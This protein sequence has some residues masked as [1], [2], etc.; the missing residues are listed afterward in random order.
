[1]PE[2]GKPDPPAGRWLQEMAMTLP[3]K[4]LMLGI[5]ACGGFYVLVCRQPQYVRAA[6]QVAKTA[7]AKT[8][9][10][11]TVAKTAVKKTTKMPA[12]PVRGFFRGIIRR[13]VPKP[14]KTPILPRGKNPIKFKVKDDPKARARLIRARDY[15]DSR[16]PQDPDD[17]KRLRRAESLVKDGQFDAAITLVQRLLDRQ[18][19]TLIRNDNEEWV[20][21]RQQANRLLSKF[22]GR[23]REGYR[24]KYGSAARDLLD[25]G[26][27]SGDLK[28]LADVATRYFHT[29]AG[30]EAARKLAAIYLDRGEYGIAARWFARVLEAEPSDGGDPKWLLQAAYAFR[31]AGDLPESKQL[32]KRV[33]KLVADNSLVLG[34]HPV[35]PAEWLN[36]FKAASGGNTQVSEWWTLFGTSS[37]TGTVD[38]GDPLL[39]SR[40]SQPTT[41]SHIVHRHIDR[42]LEALTDN[43]RAVIPAAVPLTVGGKVVF[44]TLRGILVV[45]AE[46]GS[47][48]WESREGISAE[49]LLSGRVPTASYD[50]FSRGYYPSNNNNGYGDYH[51]L[52][53]LLF[54]NGNY[55][56]ISSDGTRLFVIENMALLP[57]VG[58]YARYS[59]DPEQ[60]DRYR[61]S[62][63][64]NKLTAYDLN[65][66]RPVWEIGGRFRSES[67]DLQL[68][69]NYFLGVPVADRGEL[70]VVGEKDSRI[71]LHALDAKTG[72]VKWSRLIAYSDTKISQD[73]VR[74][75]I[76]AQVAVR[77]GVIVCPTS[78]GW[79]VAVD[80][81]NK[82]ILWAHRYSKPNA[83][84][85]EYGSSQVIQAATLNQRWIPSAPVISGGLVVY[86]PQEDESIVCLRLRDGKRLWQIPKGDYLYHAGVFGG[87]V[88]L[89]GKDR[90]TAVKLHDGT[91]AW[92]TPIDKSAGMPSGMGVAVG[93]EYHVPLYHGQLWTVN[94]KTGKVDRKLYLPSESQP[95]GNLTMYR[96]QVLSLTPF[97]LT[98]FEQRSALLAKIAQR[99]K[100]AR[101]DP[102]AALKEAEIAL[103]RRDYKTALASLRRVDAAKLDPSLDGRYRKAMMTTLTSVVRSDFKSHD[104]ELRQLAAFVK[105]PSEKFE[106]HR[107][108]AERH[109]ARNEFHDAFQLYRQLAR[110]NPDGPVRR[111]DDNRLETTVRFWAAGKLRDVWTRMPR[112]ARDSLGKQLAAEAAGLASA[113]SRKRLRF[114][115]LFSFHP[116]AVT[117]VK[118][119]IDESIQKGN[120]AVAEQLLTRLRRHK[121]RQIA[122]VAMERYARLLLTRKLPADAALVYLELKRKFPDVTL[123]DGRTAVKLVAELQ[124]RK[125]VNL[126][127]GDEP[128]SW[129]KSTMRIEQSGTQ[130]RSYPDQQLIVGTNGFPYFRDRSFQIDHNGQQLLVTR[131]SDDKLTW[132]VPLRGQSNASTGYYVHGASSGHLVFVLYRNVLHCLSPVDHRVVW[133]R[134]L[135]KRGTSGGMYYSYYSSSPAQ[136][137]YRPLT[138][139]REVAAVLG[140]SKEFSHQGGLAFANEN[141]VGIYGRRRLIV[142][143]TLSGN[144]LWMLRG[145]TQGSRAVATNEAVFVLSADGNSVTAYRALDGR[146]LPDSKA[147]KIAASAVGV[148]GNEFLHPE[149]TS[150]SFLGIG[151]ST[152]SW[153]LQSPLTG[154]VVWKRDYKNGA[155]FTLLDDGS[156]V[157]LPRH[158]PLEVVDRRNGNVAAY[159]FHSSTFGG[160]AQVY[161]LADRDTLFVV[162]NNNRRGGFSTVYY[163]YGTL[164]SINVSGD[165][166]AFDRTSRKLLWKKPVSGRQ[167]VMDY[168]EQSPV[169]TFNT[170]KYV[171]NGMVSHSL[172]S[173]LAIDKRTGRQLID[174]EI[175]SNQYYGS[176]SVNLSDRYVEFRTYSHRL[177]LVAVKNGPVQAIRP[178]ARGAVRAAKP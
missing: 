15:I 136:N 17:I 128:V 53:G 16:A 85:K 108:A 124:A 36:K 176:F 75:W 37:R 72:R 20:S 10:T 112:D 49:R 173:F 58:P 33:D 114:A 117:V 170:R 127:S 132:L 38:G 46:S 6:A 107:L 157:A 67:F 18:Q 97:G 99:K 24:L 153:K 154:Q 92:T 57:N 94:V 167:L 21:V 74:R 63:M 82:S 26:L 164:A 59:S 160:A 84:P 140:L 87:S 177:R 79:L 19:D 174:T 9:P 100:A 150:H 70:F 138:G 29:E 130:Y 77:D 44:R 76:T 111:G 123:G 12:N 89:V 42:L 156:L 64:T 86:T 113:D 31:R 166:Y 23:F 1:M 50:R 121:D 102:W 116:A 106:F 175:P 101:D 162:A 2:A 28:V 158:G 13:V 98:S 93:G 68:A 172:M 171:N 14:T 125:V 7:P 144:V 134:P 95:L 62:W 45:D 5:L 151:T 39:L 73:S 90:I 96:G 105:T 43:R 129:G 131:N 161:V 47:P 178:R 22:P 40:W 142:V 91:T 54:H 120:F 103:L 143:D 51:P 30:I 137:R 165:V 155:T 141:C 168:F 145:L 163:G 159:P 32:L 133:T 81:T 147:T 115:R 148:I 149:V 3:A 71:R 122:A 61:R 135:E 60:Y 69:G 56:L 4:T 110:D 27:K 119:L 88:V 65:S 41:H 104:A 8:T 118:G 139:G 35:R 48:L 66:G 109:D 83:R 11:K 152:T 34:G 146:R 80:R 25:E 55:G 169:L 126:Q 52:T 78:V